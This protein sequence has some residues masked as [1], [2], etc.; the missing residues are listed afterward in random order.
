M[1]C[2]LRQVTKYKYQRL[3]HLFTSLFV[4]VVFIKGKITKQFNNFLLFSPLNKFF[5]CL[6]DKFLIWLTKLNFYV[7]FL[8]ST[9]KIVALLISVPIVD[10]F[11]ERQKLPIDKNSI[12]TYFN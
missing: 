1:S 9:A 7:R 2:L 6:K 8:R 3:H 12:N 4:I 5:K 10:Y 11:R